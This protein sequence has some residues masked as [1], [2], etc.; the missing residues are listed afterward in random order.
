MRKLVFAG[1]VALFSLLVV[2]CS[3]ESDTPLFPEEKI[4]EELPCIW[5]PMMIW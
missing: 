4:S 3:E 1:V 5:L 2:G